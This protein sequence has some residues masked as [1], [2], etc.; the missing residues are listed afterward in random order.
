MRLKSSGED[1]RTIRLNYLHRIYVL[2]PDKPV[3]EHATPYGPSASLHRLTTAY[4]CSISLSIVPKDSDPVRP[5]ALVIVDEAHHVFGNSAT[6]TCLDKQCQEAGKIVPL[7][8]GSQA[9]SE[10]I[11]YPTCVDVAL[12]EVVR[13]SR[14]IAAVAQGYSDGSCSDSEFHSSS[15]SCAQIICALLS[16]LDAL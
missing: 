11:P 6:K 10:K 3:P 13:C 12:T 5:F 9:S 4:S 7:S 15:K 2:C 8:D 1:V 14:Y 16:L